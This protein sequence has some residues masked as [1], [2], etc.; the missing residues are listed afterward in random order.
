VIER[1]LDNVKLLDDL[2][3]VLRRKS[4]NL[5]VLYGNDQEKYFCIIQKVVNLLEGYQEEF[6][7]DKHNKK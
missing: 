3:Q 1:E 6:D 2:F 5:S 4:I 7:N